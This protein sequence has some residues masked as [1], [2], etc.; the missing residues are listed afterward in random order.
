MRRLRPLAAACL[1]AGAI[2]GDAAAAVTGAPRCTTEFVRSVG[3]NTHLSAHHSQYGDLAAVERAINYL[4][5][6]RI[7]DVAPRSAADLL[8]LQSLVA[9]IDRLRLTLIVMSDPYRALD[10][11]RVL[12]P[13]VAMVEGPNEVDHTPVRFQGLSG[14][15]AVQAVQRVIY[16]TVHADPALNGP[17]KQTPVLNFSLAGADKF[18]AYGDMTPS[19]DF[20]NVHAYARKGVPPFWMLPPTVHKV[21]SF[22]NRP[23]VVTETNFPTLIQADGNGVSETVQAKWLL[24]VLLDSFR[25]DVLA[26]FVYQLLDGVPDPGGHEFEAHFG[27]FRFDNT[28]KPAATALHSMLA[29]LHD[30]HPCPLPA[31]PMGRAGDL[32]C[33]A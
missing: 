5:I 23:A 6:D 18:A 1:I 21:L 27:L 26:T 8:S 19:A 24:A 12:A 4:G 15:D 25:N 7:R 20:A 30:P 28:P 32:G 17:G 16:A 2:T 14:V 10:S 31:H 11:I 29:L 3:A 33:G 22:L 13:H 9:A